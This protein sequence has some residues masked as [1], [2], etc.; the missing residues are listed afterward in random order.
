MSDLVLAN[1]TDSI[2]NELAS[3]YGVVTEEPEREVVNRP[4]Y[5]NKTRVEGIRVVKGKSWQEGD[6]FKWNEPNSEEIEDFEDDLPAVHEIEGF[7][8]HSEI[9]P[10]LDV[11]NDDNSE[12]ATKTICSVVGYKKG[13]TY[14]KE[15]PSTINLGYRNGSVY[16]SM[17]GGWIK[18]SEES[19]P[20]HFKPNADLEQYGFLG[21]RGK[22]CI[23]CIKCGES[24][25][26]NSKG[27]TS[28]CQ[29]DARIFVYATHF[30]RNKK[31]EQ[32][33]VAVKDLIGEDGVI[34]MFS[35][36]H[37]LGMQGNY[38]KDNPELNRD[39][40]MRFLSNLHRAFWSKKAPYAEIDPRVN[41]QINISIKPPLPKT[42]N[43]KNYL[44]FTE[45][46]PCDKEALVKAAKYWRT[47]VPYQ[48]PEVLDP[49]NW[50]INGIG[51][52]TVYSSARVDDFVEYEELP[53]LPES[54]ES[55]EPNNIPF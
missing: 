11:E 45:I 52:T 34:L 47:L 38:N 33:R 44:H 49:S 54:D 5:T 46:V 14:V 13:D 48:Q 32:V 31:N 30:I 2:L 10:K 20:D 50:I 16:G 42:K 21:S 29:P 15:L 28:E 7:I 12:R 35:L 37:K 40:Y 26:I 9:Q 36:S 22:S 27:K 41:H 3:L 53:A 39:S 55:E 17:Y 4:I 6:T 1:N 24:T 19:H 8:V 23:D 51:G 43:T 25:H 18:T